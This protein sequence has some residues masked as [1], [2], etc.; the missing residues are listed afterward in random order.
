MLT[1][2]KEIIEER[3]KLQKL[4]Y[5]TIE[6]GIY[7][8]GDIIEFRQ[9]DL[10]DGLMNMMIPEEFI[11]MPMNFQRVKY[12]SEYRPQIILTNLGLD[13]NLGLTM[14]S[15]DA[16]KKELKVIA[17]SIKNTIK[18]AY[19]DYRFFKSEYKSDED[20]PYIWFD[21]RSYAFD[22]AVYN[23]QFV[24]LIE[25]KILQGSFNCP[26]AKAEDWRKAMIQMM[27]SIKVNGGKEFERE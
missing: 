4:Q 16:D 22:D 13:I 2:E 20:C 10:F 26:Y 21:F 5:T 1:N 6:T 18:R 25:K 8:C 17:D 14:F 12:P 27:K 15:Q 19:P 23:I 9:I 11:E 3:I 24:M 7:V